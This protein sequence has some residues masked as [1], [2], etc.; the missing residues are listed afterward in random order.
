MSSDAHYLV[1]IEAI[2]IPSL[3]K[4]NGNLTVAHTINISQIL[5]T[6]KLV[7]LLYGLTISHVLLVTILGYHREGMFPT[8]PGSINL[9]IQ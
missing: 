3:H 6:V 5:V 4:I 8:A 1:N 2:I 9:I 7:T